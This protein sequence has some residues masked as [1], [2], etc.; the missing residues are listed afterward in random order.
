MMQIAC[1]ERGPVVVLAPEGEI[2]LGNAGEVND[3]IQGKLTSRRKLILDL[4]KVVYLDSSA[5]GMIVAIHTALQGPDGGQLRLCNLEDEVFE[6]FK[7]S[8]LDSFLNIDLTL[9]ESLAA[10]R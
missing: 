1:E 5:V 2:T 7:A 8:S 3:F 6:V 9:D 10:M 4:K